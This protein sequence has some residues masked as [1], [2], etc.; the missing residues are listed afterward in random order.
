MKITLSLGLFFV[1]VAMMVSC[2]NGRAKSPERDIVKEPEAFSEHLSEDI[3][4]I[5][6]VLEDTSGK[7]DDSLKITYSDW[8]RDYYEKNDYAAIWSVQKQWKPYSQQLFR[9]I[10]SSMQYGLFPKDY[11]LIAI[12]SLRQRFATDSNEINNAA[13]WARL[14]VILTDAFFMLGK[15]LKLGHFPADSLSVPK[16]DSI[17]G[18]EFFSEQLAELP[19]KNNLITVLDSL[20]PRIEQYHL[21]KRELKKFLDTVQFTAATYVMYPYKDTLKFRKQLQQRL[22]ELDMLKKFDPAMDTLALRSVIA[23]F[24][25]LKGLKVDSVA[26]E[27]VV[28]ELNN[29]N[30]EKFKRIAINLDRY[31]QLPN[32]MPLRYIFVNIPSYMLVVHDTDSVALVSKVVVGNPKTRTP[33]LTSEVYE[34]VTMPYWNVPNSIIIKEMLKKIIANPG[35]LAKNGYVV[36]NGKGEEMDPYKIPW[37]KYV[38]KKGI[39]Y[40]IRQNSGD[41]NSLGVIKFNFRNQYSVYMHDTNA[42]GYFNRKMRALSHGCVRVQEWEKLAGFLSGGD[43]I[44]V[45]KD[46]A[47][48]ERVPLVID[49]IKAWIAREERHHYALKNRVPV[50]FRYITCE[51]KDDQLIFYDDI[52]KEDKMLREKYFANKSF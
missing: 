40:V 38:G 51:V 29:T 5:C 27:A 16:A 43:S 47:G 25:R 46:N 44:R 15:H 24:Q 7:L 20:E 42:R 22:V 32:P 48:F 39:P 31:R 6:H 4:K 10:D 45:R 30:W 8:V 2:N 21:I 23:K 41:D 49:T 1:F 9:F 14:D 28:S 26:G 13:T 3:K 52:Y 17:Y 18:K 33:L 12:H 11:H 35:Y 19:I 50:F 36:L 37:S 34:F